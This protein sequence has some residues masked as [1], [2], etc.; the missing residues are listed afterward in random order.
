MNKAL[1]VKEEFRSQYPDLT[2]FELATNFYEITSDYLETF[3]RPVSI[4]L[5]TG[6]EG[7]TEEYR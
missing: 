6:T 7:F 5:P 2:D 1:I 3:K 4:K